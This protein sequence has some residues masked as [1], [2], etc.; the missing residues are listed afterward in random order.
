MQSNV[1][2]RVTI[3]EKSKIDDTQQCVDSAIINCKPHR[4]QQAYCKSWND[5]KRQHYDDFLV[6]FLSTSGG[7]SLDS[8][9]TVVVFL[10]IFPVPH[11]RNSQKLMKESLQIT[12]Y[13]P[14]E[15]RP[16]QPFTH[17][18]AAQQSKHSPT[19]QQHSSPNAHR[20]LPFNTRRIGSQMI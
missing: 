4:Q 7:F 5:V 20:L 3:F 12:S 11:A 19:S 14:T 8:L 15:R 17:Q 9:A 18:S 13:Q 1:I 6:H 2:C 10:N 16:P